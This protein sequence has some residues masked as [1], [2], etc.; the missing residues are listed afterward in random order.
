MLSSSTKEQVSGVLQPP[1]SLTKRRVKHT[2]RRRVILT[3]SVPKVNLQVFWSIWAYSLAS[4]M[5][6][7][8]FSPKDSPLVTSTYLE[9]LL[10]A[11]W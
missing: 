6:M 7:A 1:P 9:R 4:G 2:S 5:G 10:K 11:Y 8:V 3:E